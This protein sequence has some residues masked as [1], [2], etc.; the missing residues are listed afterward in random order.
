MGKKTY[1]FFQRFTLFVISAIMSL[2]LS[3]G[4]DKEPL[5]TDDV[6]ISLD[7]GI[8]SMVVGDTRTLTAT[9]KPTVSTSNISW[10]S[11]NPE[12]AAIENG[13][14]TA[15]NLG[16]TTISAKIGNSIA[17]CE[18]SVRE[19]T[20]LSSIT[21]LTPTVGVITLEPAEW[22]KKISFGWSSVEG[23]ADYR[24]K[25]SKTN[26]FE[27]GDILYSA[28]STTNRLDV[29]HYDLNEAVKGLP[30]SNV[31]IFWTVEPETTGPDL[32]PSVAFL[33]LTLDRKEY[34]KLAESGTEN[35]MLQVLDGGY[36]YSIKTTGAAKVNTVPLVAAHTSATP[37]VSFRYKSNR[38]LA[39]ATVRFM[40]GT[41]VRGTAERKISRAPYWKEWRLYQ[42]SLPANWGAP[43]DYLQIDF[44][45][46][47][48]YE[49]E[50]NAIHLSAPTNADLFSWYEP[51]IL[52]ATS[53][54][55]AIEVLEES[56]NYFKFKV[57]AHSSTNPETDPHRTD[58][59]FWVQL[60]QDLPAEATLFSFEFKS[61]TGL[62]WGGEWLNTPWSADGSAEP[63]VGPIYDY[64]E[65]YFGPFDIFGTGGNSSKPVIPSS[66]NPLPATTE[67]KEYTI[68][69]SAKRAN[70]A[71]T[72]WGKAGHT[73]RIDM[74]N[75]SLGTTFEISNIQIKIP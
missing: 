37:V 11:S 23:V 22:E 33:N 29:L 61:D 71:F 20:V 31:S 4:D 41:T 16:R 9:L 18:V 70:P 51:E 73:L 32:L 46:E 39:K 67:W 62:K 56:D 27:E 36:H 52:A 26:K 42:E 49:I 45:D 43:G 68:D 66:A 55:T 48:G 69:M 14:I 50:L 53:S 47:P 7:E 65:I 54:I 75:W 57:T 25:I 30:N 5:L 28:T 13:T 40:S 8:I 59:Y 44:G 15:V 12:V 34:L 17:Q 64:V 60:G 58:P 2:V 1:Y 72:E 63:R 6:T 74:G 35:M 21:L 24:L 10:T 38:E 19:S 3:C